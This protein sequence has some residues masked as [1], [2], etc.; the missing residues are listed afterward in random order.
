MSTRRLTA[1]IW[2]LLE[3]WRISRELPDFVGITQHF[4]CTRHGASCHIP[5]EERVQIAK[6]TPALPGVNL[7][8][9]VDLSIVVRHA[10]GS[11]DGRTMCETG[12]SDSA[13]GDVFAPHTVGLSSGQFSSVLRNP[14]LCVMT[15]QRWFSRAWSSLQ[16]WVGAGEAARE[17][18]T[19]SEQ[20]VPA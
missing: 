3:S 2:L 20:A 9:F 8:D 17:A 10:G 18:W 1:K 14:L 5:I 7:V 6:S 4:T 16:R 11:G 13:D 15:L 12:G 19:C